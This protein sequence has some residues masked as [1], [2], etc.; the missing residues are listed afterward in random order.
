MKRRKGDAFPNTE[1]FVLKNSKIISGFVL[2][3][4]KIPARDNVWR[5]LA[6]GTERCLSNIRVA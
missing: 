3:S 1:L 5:V 2:M 6:V 4:S